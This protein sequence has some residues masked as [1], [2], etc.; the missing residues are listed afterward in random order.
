MSDNIYKIDN[1]LKE[2][3]RKLRSENKKIVFTNGVFD[4]IHRGH[5]EYLSEARKKGDVLI[6]GLNSDS[7]V[8]KIK[9]KNRPVV[10]ENDRAFILVN[11]KPVDFVAIFEEDTPYNLIKVIL[12]DVLVKGGDWKTEDI[13]GSDIVMEHGGKVLS[14]KYIDGYS[15]TGIIKNISETK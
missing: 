6:V 14:L 12:P 13:V 8:K 9:G 4:I 7:S 1:D 11:L 3:V 2:L 15:T 5:I 10:N